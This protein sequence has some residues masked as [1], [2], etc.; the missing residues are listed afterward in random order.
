VKAA[1]LFA[2]LAAAE[3]QAL[4]P[5]AHER[6]E[7]GQTR[8]LKVAGALVAESSDAAVVSAEAFKTDE[9]VLEAKG[10]GT[11]LVYVFQKDRLWVARVDV[12][13]VVP[14]KD[15]ARPAQ[16]KFPEDNVVEV[17]TPECRRALLSYF[18]EPRPL[19]MTFEAT[20]LSEQLKEFAAALAAAGLPHV[21]LRYSGTVLEIGSTKD[22][23]E[24]R[25]VLKAIFPRACGPL[26]FERKP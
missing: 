10:K 14:R 12:G 5:D 9:V 6:L 18:E 24:M 23:A 16:C 1:A 17:A 19:E 13:A 4:P 2:A 3:S 25:A 8:F 20:V 26:L 21:T 22:D 11:A 7:P 15:S